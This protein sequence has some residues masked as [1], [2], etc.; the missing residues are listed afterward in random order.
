MII[1]IGHSNSCFEICFF[2]NPWLSSIGQ[3]LDDRLKEKLKG[4]PLYSLSCVSVCLSVCNWATEHT[5]WHRD[6]IFGLSDPCDMREETH[7][8]VFR[9]IH[10][11][12][13]YWHFSI[14][15]L[16]NT[17][18]FL[19]SSYRSQFFTWECDIWVERTLYHKKLKTFENVQ[20]IF[21]CVLRDFF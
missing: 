6:L 16:N 4:C 1:H 13:F 8:F 2:F 19:V 3:I 7:L 11:Y 12:A 9:N 20:K 10:F 21:F 15:S 14:V 18:K 5:F 17:S